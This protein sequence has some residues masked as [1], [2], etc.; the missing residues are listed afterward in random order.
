MDIWQVWVIAGVAM[1]GLEMFAPGFVL[2]LL[3]VAALVTSVFAAYGTTLNTQLLSFAVVTAA[4][5]LG[6]RPLILRY[7]HRRVPGGST[8]AGALIGRTGRVLEPVDDCA[9]TGRIKLGSEEWKAISARALVL[10]L[11]AR[12]VVRRVEGCKLVVESV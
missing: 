3:G 7:F 8:N 1:L 12:V 2:A 4:L 6:V 10:P 11:G 9:G 5:T